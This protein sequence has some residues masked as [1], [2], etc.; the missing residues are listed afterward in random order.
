MKRLIENTVCSGF[1]M[2][3]RLATWPTRISPSFAKPTT[4]GVRRWPSVLGMTTGSPPSTTATTELVVPRSMPMTLAIACCLLKVRACPLGRPGFLLADLDLDFAR[5]D[6]FQLREPDLEDA[7]AVAGPDFLGLD[8]DRKLDMTLE[9]AGP[10][11][12]PV[13]LLLGD[14]GGD[15]A[16][17]AKAQNVA[18]HG[19]VDVLL[20]HPWE[21]DCH[22][23]LV[24]GLVDIDRRCPG[25]LGC[26]RPGPAT[27]IDVERPVDLGRHVGQLAEQVR[28][29]NPPAIHDT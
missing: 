27:E 10:S 21:L 7:V 13:V 11:L 24:P 8:R 3:G 20:A 4:A 18:G 16:L 23:E 19:E 26:G 17:S 28:P 2:A 14:L 25:P 12:D 22:D 15:A 29:L 1:G 6:L 5:R 9:R